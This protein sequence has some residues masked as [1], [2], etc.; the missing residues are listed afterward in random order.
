MTLNWNDQ[1]RAGFIALVNA[2]VPT[3]VLLGVVDWTSEQVAGVMA[4]VVAGT[5]FL[6]LLFKRGQSAA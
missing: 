1:T 3:L 6:G 2:V 4:S 5:T